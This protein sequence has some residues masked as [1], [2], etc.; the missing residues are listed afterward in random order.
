MADKPGPKKK[1]SKV[2]IYDDLSGDH[3]LSSD[4]SHLNI[5]GSTFRRT[6]LPS[7]AVNRRVDEEVVVDLED[8]DTD[9]ADQQTDTGL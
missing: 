9:S 7:V 1:V 3:V 6:I 2:K 4:G 8:I 5:G